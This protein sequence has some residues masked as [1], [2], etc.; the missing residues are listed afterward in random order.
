MDNE[1]S[2]KLP[3][4]LRIQANGRKILALRFEHPEWTHKQIGEAVGVSTSR[5]GQILSH[6]R[7]K[8]CMAL[9]ARQRIPD[10]LPKAVKAYEHMITQSSNL[11]V[12]EKAAG[13]ILTDQ[14]VFDVPETRVLV[15]IT[16]KSVHEL[17]EIVAKAK[18]LPEN[19]IDA[20]LVTE[21]SDQLT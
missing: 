5:V 19:V 21:R 15:E 17:R 14:K 20:E 10:L 9:V 13:R 16:Q 11:I 8:Q 1:I 6:P 18:D 7:I 3:N 12:A 2:F 4:D